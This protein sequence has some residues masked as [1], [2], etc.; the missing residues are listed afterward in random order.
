MCGCSGC[1]LETVKAMSISE[2][3]HARH[4]EVGNLGA[5]WTTSQ[6]ACEEKHWSGSKHG[7][8]THHDVV[9]RHQV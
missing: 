4:P 9:C 3:K 1:K 2:R 7:S 8:G 5:M 6:A